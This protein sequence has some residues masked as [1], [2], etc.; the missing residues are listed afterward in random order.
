MKIFLSIVPPT[1]TAQEHQVKV[2]RGRPF[3]YDPPKVKYAREVLRTNL[4]LHRPPAPLTGPVKLRAVW[5][6]PKGK[7][8]KDGEWK[9][10]RPDTD[11][12]QKLL[13]DC[14]TAEGFWKDDAQVA[15]EMVE[16][17]W[18]ADPVGIGIEI[19]LLEGG[20]DG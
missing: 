3:F 10:T 15:V 12:L 11:N 17:K 19:E 18:S 7:T 4:R 1:T 2:I 16:K 9:I 20:L 8:H 5:Y 14:M 13:K 6:F